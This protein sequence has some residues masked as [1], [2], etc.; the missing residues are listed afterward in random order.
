M[1]ILSMNNN[2]LEKL[3]HKKWK[4]NLQADLINN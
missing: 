4:Q 2:T 1:E 3:F